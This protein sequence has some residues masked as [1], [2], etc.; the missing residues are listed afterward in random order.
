[1]MKLI[2]FPKH[3][4]QRLEWTGIDKQGSVNVP[5]PFSVGGSRIE[6]NDSDD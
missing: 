5:A 4:H 2:T 6:T 3:F 1:M